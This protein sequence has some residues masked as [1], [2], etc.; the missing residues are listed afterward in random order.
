MD[1]FP[2]GLQREIQN[3]EWIR[4]NVEGKT[5]YALVSEALWAVEEK[6]N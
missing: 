5:P 4:K 3:V 6:R 1:C 2:D